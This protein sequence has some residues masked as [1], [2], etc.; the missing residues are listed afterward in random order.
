MSRRRKSQAD[1]EY[2]AAVGKRIAMTRT[3]LHVRAL[4]LAA[5]VQVSQQALSSYECGRTSCSP[6]VLARIAA[7]LGVSLSAL[8]PSTTTCCLFVESRKKSLQSA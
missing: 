8:M 1:W 7:A 2:D 4:D 5:A 6:V 3:A